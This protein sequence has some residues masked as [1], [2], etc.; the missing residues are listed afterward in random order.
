[1]DDET[2]GMLRCPLTHSAL[3]REGDWL[4][5]E[6]GGLKYPIEDGIAILLIDRATLPADVRTLD[7]LKAQLRAT[8]QLAEQGG[9]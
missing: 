7:E 6:V 4:V 5:A 3:R 2:L 8:G 1:M 9:T